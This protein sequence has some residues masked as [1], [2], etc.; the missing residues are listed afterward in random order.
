MELIGEN[1]SPC[2]S[3][4]LSRVF[5]AVA[6]C[7]N[8][9]HLSLSEEV[10]TVTVGLLESSL[11][12]VNSAVL[13]KI[14]LVLPCNDL[15]AGSNSLLTH[16]FKGFLNLASLC[17]RETGEVLISLDIFKHLVIDSA[18]AVAP[19]VAVHG[20]ADGVLI[21]ILDPVCLE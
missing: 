1:L 8:C 13:L 20:L 21:G 7:D 5:I 12:G 17:F 19:A 16:I 3:K 11:C 14:K 4:L 10:L 15:V 2:E 18:A 9:V 6:F